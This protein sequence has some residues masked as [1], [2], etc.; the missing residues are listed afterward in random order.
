[1]R[2]Q[3]AVAG[4]PLTEL[5]TGALLEEVYRRRVRLVAA[6]MARVA[7]AAQRDRYASSRP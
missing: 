2:R 1:M 6:Q 3:H 7:A 5:G 4:V